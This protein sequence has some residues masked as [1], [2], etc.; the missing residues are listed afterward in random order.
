VIESVGI[1]AVFLAFALAV[2]AGA[3]RV[4]ILV[5]VRLDR[6]LAARASA[7][8]EPRSPIQS[9]MPGARNE[10]DMLTGKPGVVEP[11][12]REE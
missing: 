2:F 11:S 4:G 9:S 10:P 8:A 6:I 7:D 5:G 12:G 3:V 1:V